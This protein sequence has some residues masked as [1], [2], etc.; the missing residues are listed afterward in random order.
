M[1]LSWGNSVETFGARIRRA[2]KMLDQ[3]TQ[4]IVD[5]TGVDTKRFAEAGTPVDT[6]ALRASWKIQTSGKGAKRKV[7]IANT[8]FDRTGVDYA[9]FVEYGTIKMA[10]RR[11]LTK[12]LVKADRI[13]Q[14]RLKELNKR[15]ASLYNRG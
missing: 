5:Q 15:L 12:A 8:V 9:P 11:M 13:K 6:G 3:G 14:R 7:V 10:P 2:N 1:T 4:K